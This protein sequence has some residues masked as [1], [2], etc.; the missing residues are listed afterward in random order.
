MRAHVDSEPAQETL[1]AFGNSQPNRR[2]NALRCLDERDLEI[3]LG[4]DSIEAISDELSGGA[5][6]LGGEFRAR[7]SRAD[8]RDVQLPGA[9]WAGLCMSPN[10][11]FD[12]PLMKPHRLLL[13]VEGDGEFLG[14]ASAEVIACAAHS[15]DQ[16]VVDDASRRDPFALGV[17][18]GGQVNLALCPVEADHLPHAIPKV[19]VRSLGEIIDR[20]AAH[21]QGARGYLV[22]VRLPDMSAAAL[23]KRDLRL[24]APAQTVSK[25]SGKF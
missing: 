21:V 3:L 25:L 19:V 17:V 6:E 1:S 2:N 13:G 22:Q 8:N 15:D 10:E 16:G 12:E 24:L 20:I 11:P 23:D 9:D 5:V 7:S 14:P 18:G 4:I